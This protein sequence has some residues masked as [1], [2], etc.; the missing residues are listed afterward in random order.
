VVGARANIGAGTITCNYDGINKHLT[1]IGANAFIGSNSALVAPVSIG[2]GAYIASGSV[3]TEDV[4]DDA[5]AFARARQENKPGR[6]VLIRERN[7]A[8][9]DAKKKAAE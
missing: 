1:R 5:V 2:N 4:P 6:A 3:V 7:Q 9:K 8:I